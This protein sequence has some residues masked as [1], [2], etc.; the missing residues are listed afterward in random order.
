MH[1]PPAEGTVIGIEYVGRY[2][3]Y[4]VIT[5]EDGR[6]Q[7]LRGV[8]NEIQLGG[9]YRFEGGCSPVTATRID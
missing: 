8:V 4:T 1:P 3:D 5:F 9:D 2:A 6:V 7:R